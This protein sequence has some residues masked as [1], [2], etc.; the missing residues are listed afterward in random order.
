[1]KLTFN[2]DQLKKAAKKM[3]ADEIVFAPKLIQTQD[4]ELIEE[5]S[6]SQGLSINPEEIEVKDGLLSYKGHQVV[7][8]IPDHS[9]RGVV[10]V[11]QNKN[12]GNKYHIA[13][14]STIE[15]MK[16]KGRYEQRY[17]ASRNPNGIFKIFD[18][19]QETETPLNICQNCLKHINFKNFRALS[20]DQR[21][22]FVDHI[23][24]DDILS[25]YSTFFKQLPGVQHKHSIGY[26]DDWPQISRQYRA[27]QN[28]CC[29]SCRVN[30]INEK[31]LLHTHHINHNKR[32][33]SDSNLRA[34]C[35]DCHRKQDNHDH[36]KISLQQMQKI[37]QLRRAQ[38][39]LNDLEDW[40]SAFKYADEGLHG[41][42]S[43]YQSKGNRVPQVGY[44]L[45]DTSGQTVAEL[46]IAWPQNQRGIAIDRQAIAAAQNQG[47]KVLSVGEAIA[48]MNGKA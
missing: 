37:T 29:E 3:G 28:Y 12:I 22:H 48:L 31:E 32:D 18:S 36:M 35:I 16:R 24:I 8:F 27:S 19:F 30:L 7:L 26:T 21:L 6:T 23:K 38:G 40:E 14:C 34:L 1:M 4:I 43:Y 25:V 17:N 44:S 13:E 42:M 2:F 41:L 11:L 39:L 33:N 9:Y 46:D 45:K 5:L 10:T 15:G 20:Y 47:W